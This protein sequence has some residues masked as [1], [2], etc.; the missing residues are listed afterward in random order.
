MGSL[1]GPCVVGTSGGALSIHELLFS[2]KLQGL[3]DL[4]EHREEGPSPGKSEILTFLVAHLCIRE[5]P[6]AGGAHS[7]PEE[8]CGWM[9]GGTVSEVP[10]GMVVTDIW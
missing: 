6:E 3:L 5:V 2:R 4:K 1:A 9:E 10:L 8:V 7:Q